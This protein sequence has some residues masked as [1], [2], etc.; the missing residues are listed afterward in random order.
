MDDT[1]AGTQLSAIYDFYPYIEN[2]NN[3]RKNN[4]L[5]YTNLSHNTLTTQLTSTSAWNTE[6]YK[7]IDLQI[8]E[9]LSL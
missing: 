9:G 1:T 2:Y 3:E 6:V 8:R 4:I 7:N 5:D